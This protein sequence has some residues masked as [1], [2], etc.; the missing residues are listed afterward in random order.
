MK[1]GICPRCK[2]PRTQYDWEPATRICGRCQNADELASDEIPVEEQND[3]YR[4]FCEVRRGFL[5]DPI[6]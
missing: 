5:R 3:V 6:S 2:R 4:R 1:H